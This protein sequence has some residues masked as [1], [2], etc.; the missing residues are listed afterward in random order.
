[1]YFEVFEGYLGKI[2]DCSI[3]AFPDI[4]I[5]VMDGQETDLSSKY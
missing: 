3:Y 4:D 5:L 2:Q 1:M